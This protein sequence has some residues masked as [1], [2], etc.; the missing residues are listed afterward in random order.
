MTQGFSY[1]LLLCFV[2]V[3]PPVPRTQLDACGDMHGLLALS[4]F[5]LLQEFHTDIWRP[6]SD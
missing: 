5:L 1:L 2:F 6:G 3:L 4:S